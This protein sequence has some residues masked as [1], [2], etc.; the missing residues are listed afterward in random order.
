[1]NQKT[2]E[3]LLPISHTMSSY[4]SDI[5]FEFTDREMAS[6]FYNAPLRHI[7]NS[8]KLKN[9][10]LLKEDT[11]DLELKK[12]IEERLDFEK[13]KF[14]LFISISNN[15]YLY[16]VTGMVD[17]YMAVYDTYDKAK[18]YGDKELQNEIYFI[19]KGVP[20]QSFADIPFSI[21]INTEGAINRIYL[22]H[23]MCPKGLFDIDY[24][25]KGRFEIAPLKF[26]IPFQKLDTVYCIYD[27]EKELGV[28][29]DKVTDWDEYINKV[30]VNGE[31]SDIKLSVEYGPE[32]LDILKVNPL[33]LQ[34]A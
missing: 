34:K 24:H 12:E 17:E 15:K 25:N 26:P 14:D 16:I 9:L 29:N 5:G 13:A 27:Y 3:K 21:N 11:D 18:K 23:D 4:F 31:Y 32:K 22:S 2:F 1:M 28:L 10:T 7:G 33:F 20:N 8:D 30:N 6:L 19:S